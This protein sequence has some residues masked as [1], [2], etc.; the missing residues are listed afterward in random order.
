M[1]LDNDEKLIIHLDDID[2]RTKMHHYIVYLLK[3]QTDW[4]KRP[5][6]M[7]CIGSDRYIGDALGPLV[8]TY[9]EENTCSIIYGS[10]D[11]PVHAGNL[12]QVIEMIHQQHCQPIIIAVDACLG[13]SNEVGNMEI[14]QGSLEAGIAVGACLPC[15]GHISIIGV[16]SESGRIGYLDLQSTPLSIVMKISKYIGGALRDAIHSTRTDYAMEL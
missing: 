9:L 13:K 3:K 7:L 5:L 4:D 8:G 15:V 14:W 1:Q 2:V 12:V 11:K 16:V 10:L 6:I